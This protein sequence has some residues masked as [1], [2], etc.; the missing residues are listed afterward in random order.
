MKAIFPIIVALFISAS[1]T[2]VRA[3]EIVMCIA[4]YPCDDNGRLLAEYSDRTNPCYTYFLEQCAEAAAQKAE[5]LSEALDKAKTR[6]R[7][8]KSTKR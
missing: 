5:S 6:I 1:P 8:L 2:L 4:V 3:E 7:N